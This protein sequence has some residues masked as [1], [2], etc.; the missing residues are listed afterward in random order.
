MTANEFKQLRN[1][2][3]VFQIHIRQTYSEKISRSSSKDHKA[4]L[5][6]RRYSESALCD[7]MLALAKE[8]AIRKMF[9]EMAKSLH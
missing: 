4:L 3:L 9:S 5:S 2:I 7:Q 6:G 1:L 8:K